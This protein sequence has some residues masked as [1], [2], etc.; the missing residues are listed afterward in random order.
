MN[1]VS[2]S[3]GNNRRQTYPVGLSRDKN[4]TADY[5]E[6]AAHR[7]IFGSMSHALRWLRLRQRFRRISRRQASQ[8]PRRCD[9]P[10][11]SPLKRRCRFLLGFRYFPGRG[12]LK[13]P[14]ETQM[15]IE[16]MHTGPRM[17]QVVIHDT[18]V[19]VAG[20]VASG[21]PEA[22]GLVPAIGILRET[23]TLY[24]D[25]AETLAG[26]RLHDHPAFEALHHLGAQLCQTDHFGCDIVGFDV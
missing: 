1:S 10:A 24:P 15:A 20:Q 22:P 13:C 8:L 18:T 26:R 11:A 17:S 12:R 16:R 19:Y 6:Y 14:R 21:A 5:K 7:S 4:Y 25:D 3:N 23:G 2:A 9:I